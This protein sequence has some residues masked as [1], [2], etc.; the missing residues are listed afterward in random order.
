MAAYFDASVVLS[1]LVVDEHA[2]RAGAL[3]SRHL[4]R[5]TSTL[6]LIEALTVARRA[7]QREP[8]RAKKAAEDRLEALMEEVALKPLDAEIAERLRA[9]PELADCR[10]LDAAHLATALY[11][12][13]ADP[14]L[15][16]CT[17]DG[18]MAELA[19]RVGL[20]C[21]GVEAPAS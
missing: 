16:V 2:G 10:S 3:W 4:D 5:V 18:W 15:V 6:T 17:F 11:F 12:K 21:E 19:T 14:D 20:V 8:A 1:L 7:L 13:V 9:A